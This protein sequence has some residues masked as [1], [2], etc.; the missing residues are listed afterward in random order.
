MKKKLP[1]KIL[2]AFLAVMM[3]ATSIPFSAITAFAATG[4]VDAAT[5]EKVI[6]VENAMD[7]FKSKLSE[8]GK[9]YSNVSPA[10]AAYVNCQQGL[11]AYIYGGEDNAL[12][13]LADALNTAVNNMQEF[14]GIEANTDRYR[15][16]QIYSADST[17]Y[18][19][20]EY[21]Q[22][23]AN[24]LWSETG[25]GSANDGK[26][27][28]SDGYAAVTLYYPEVTLMYDGKTDPVTSMMAV[29]SG[30]GDW[31]WGGNATSRYISAITMENSSDTG[32]V[33]N[34]NWHGT[35]GKNLDFNWAWITNGKD[36]N[37]QYNLSYNQ[38]DAGSVYQIRKGG[39]VAVYKKY[40]K[41]FANLLTF[42]DGDT[43]FGDNRW[44]ID[45]QPQ[46]KGHIG[47]STDFIQNINNGASVTVDGSTYI[48]IVNYKQVIDNVKSAGAKM[49]NTDLA[50]Y[51]QGGLTSYFTAMDAATSFDPN[52]YFKDSNDVD[53]YCSAASNVVKN[54]KQAKTT[55]TNETVASGFQAIRDAMGSQL[56]QT[57]ANG[58]DK[59]TADSWQNFVTAY[60]SARD[61]M[62]AANDTKLSNDLSNVQNIYYYNSQAKDYTTTVANALLEA[63]NAL[64]TNVAKVD[65]SALVAYINQFQSYQPDFFTTE[66]YNA[67]SQAVKE[68][69][70]D[71]W[72]SEEMWG[73]PANAPDDDA[74]GVGKAKVAA[75]IE[76]YKAAF[77]D[78]RIS[79]AGV[80][81]T[82]QGRYSLDEAIALESKIA[83][84]TDYSNYADFA[85]LLA[86]AKAYKAKLASTEM[87]DYDAQYEEYTNTVDALV[88][89]YNGLLY[90]FT[91][92]PD[93]TV[94]GNTESDDIQRIT[95]KDQGSTFIEGS[96][97]NQGIVFRTD[98]TAKQVKF[99][100]FNVTYGTTTNS[101]KD[102][103]LDSISINAT[104][105]KLGD[106][107]SKAHITNNGGGTGT[108]KPKGLS[109]EQRATYAGCL[110]YSNKNDEDMPFTFSVSN[111]RYTGRNGSNVCDVIITKNDGTQVKDHATA[112]QTPLDEILGTT[113]GQEVTP[114][115]G[116]VFAQS[117]GND[118]E[119]YSYIKGDFNI[120]I[121]ATEKQTLTRDTVP[122]LSTFEMQ[123]RFGAVG[124]YKCQNF[125]IWAGYNWFTS[126][127]TDTYLT[128]AVKVIDISS[129]VELV[130]ECN[131]LTKDSQKYTEESW[132]KFTA[133]LKNAQNNINYTNMTSSDSVRTLVNTI[134]KTR[135]QTLW[136]A[137]A[138]LVVKTLTVN[139]KY[140]KDLTSL[141]P[142]IKVTY[143]EKISAADI[144]R[145]NAILK[146][147]Y[148]AD[149]YTWIPNGFT[150][151]FDPEA[152]VTEDIDL[153]VN[154]EK[155]D[156][157]PASWD[158]YNSAK[159]ALIAK[160]EGTDK[161]A[162]DALTNVK[163]ELAKLT[164][165]TLADNEK[166]AYTSE[167]QSAIDAET[168]TITSLTNNLT[169]ISLTS[170]VLQVA[171]AAQAAQGKDDT[172][173]YDNVASKIDYK[174][175]VTFDMI[176]KDASSSALTVT[177][178]K[179]STDSALEA[180][181]KAALNGLELK[182]YDIY[183]ND[184]K[185]G[186]VAYG[187]PVSVTPTKI[188]STTDTTVKGDGAN[189]S[190]TYSYTAPS[191]DPNFGT[192]SQ[193]NSTYLSAK[194]FML[195]APSL[196]FIV[197][198]ET[199]LTATQVSTGKTGYTVTFKSSVNRKVINVIN[200]DANGNFKMPAAPS[201]PYYTF[202]SYS[203][204]VAPN[205]DATVSQDTV[206]TVNYTADEENL[207]TFYVYN[208]P[209]DFLY[210]TPSE[211][212]D[213][214]N[215][216]G[217]ENAHDSVAY[218]ELVNVNI[219]DS[220]AIAKA[221]YDEDSF[222]YWYYILAYGDTY[223]FYAHE[224]I[225][226]DT[227][228]V[229]IV[230]ITEE[231]Y[232]KMQEPKNDI[233]Y[234]YG[235]DGERIV[236]EQNTLTGEYETKDL[237]F[238][239]YNRETPV[240]AA[241]NSKFSLIG[242][243]IC[244]TGYEMVETGFLMTKGDSSLTVENAADKSKGVS[245]FKA[246]KYTVG[247]QF[248]IN[249]KTPSTEQSFK[250][251]AYAKYKDK[252]GNIVTKYGKVISATT[253]NS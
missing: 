150:T 19:A 139:V 104:A 128:P 186:T 235:T 92:I 90:S 220:Y 48:H 132:A 239:V 127:M 61:E 112:T 190:W 193:D 50:N 225:G 66:T 200:T 170:D 248:V 173:M 174:G 86:D 201:V 15:T 126:E 113:N 161:F 96:Y 160:L 116:G 194:K 55:D 223:S 133:A 240:F 12:D 163:N 242:T 124:S 229:G 138:N 30:E 44:K 105:P 171:A 236:A 251:V 203:N 119:A 27:A 22:T 16:V 211:V 99:G 10:Y 149:G 5:D 238:E 218:N 180:A 9:S 8:E 219:P 25:V 221:V 43:K 230:G 60:E 176:T 134:L 42:T 191:R 100:D 40:Q 115:V 155:G 101:Y 198:G 13:G 29:A 252:S 250:Y 33:F 152:V 253:A 177:G 21:A 54:V 123:T 111:L 140:G 81:L 189:Y 143:G 82:T 3:V 57:Y 130:A 1:K 68:I 195:T 179:Y 76:K 210:T 24:L 216:K 202:D 136:D 73:V 129:L 26:Q 58:G 166:S 154:Y 184:T 71:V 97:T 131:A 164:F 120:D 159:A 122:S 64:K 222:E 234:V 45:V 72:G 63:Y 17:G 246:S 59:Y 74:E 156:A 18:S 77:A 23:Y 209:D 32:F 38:T 142:A 56:R 168:A 102:N 69:K 199:H 53:G 162:Y 121:P 95:I 36:D 78:L 103:A 169:A 188:I 98:H 80:V 226:D 110:S 94:Y 207:Y 224:S 249:I 245:R 228:Y 65:T 206:I 147:T 141:D 89:A 157:L 144:A 215:S 185:I 247:N 241:D 237:E 182:T 87:T 35:S 31:A 232:K 28:S 51:T 46:V 109:D 85:T 49:K 11:D 172:D 20:E 213:T 88:K 153:T 204:G 181:I 37:D 197:K 84:P 175:D 167:S 62:A 125:N 217:V 205:T 107:G 146:E 4:Y 108:V 227:L 208:N 165:F 158:A 212:W 137:R 79:S 196:G 41:Y 118:D 52:N 148:E 106:N 244:P 114:M 145:I 47:S 187:T 83:D 233:G 6:A 67:A 192:S 2:A 93:G 7:A 34:K 183:V 231:Q 151:T 243:F 91:K 14:N 178:Y 135:Y 70:T 75:A 214:E 117:D 39:T